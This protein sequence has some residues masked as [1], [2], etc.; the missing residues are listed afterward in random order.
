MNAM[1]NFYERLVRQ[2]NDVDDGI[3][4]STKWKPSRA[5]CKPSSAAWR[6]EK[7]FAPHTPLPR[8]PKTRLR[9]YFGFDMFFNRAF[10]ALMKKRGGS[11]IRLTHGLRASRLAGA[12]LGFHFVEQKTTDGKEAF[13]CS[14]KRN[15]G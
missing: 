13:P 10:G 11:R 3:A 1:D 9:L 15:S 6:V 4:C 7:G 2:V 8:V 5:P 14:L 12:A